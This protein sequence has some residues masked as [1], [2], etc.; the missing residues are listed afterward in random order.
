MENPL[1]WNEAQHKARLIQE[2]KKQKALQQKQEKEENLNLA[3]DEL[4]N[5]LGT[6]GFRYSYFEDICNDY[7]IDEDDLLDR[8]I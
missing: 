8:I 7:G 3:S 4:W 2:Q 6:E 5:A 1:E